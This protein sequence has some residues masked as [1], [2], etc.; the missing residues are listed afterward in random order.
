MNPNSSRRHFARSAVAGGALIAASVNAQ[1]QNPQFTRIAARSTGSVH[2]GL[3]DQARE[4]L[5]QSSPVAEDGLKK[6]V[7]ELTARNL[8]PAPAAAALKRLI[9]ALASAENVPAMV[10]AA[11]RMLGEV[12]DAADDLAAAIGDVVRSSA[13]YVLQRLK[14]DN[15]QRA[16]VV[17][18]SDFAGGLTGA[19]AGAKLGQYGAIVGCAIGASS[20]SVNAAFAKR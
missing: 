10:E 4:R 8:V 19:A 12:S 11:R 5:G 16:L 17:I 18:F 3:L 6:L 7:D 20:A 2:T 15:V 14:E 9:D 13:E 1:T